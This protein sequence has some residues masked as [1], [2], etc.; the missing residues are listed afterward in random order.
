MALEP[1]HHAHLVNNKIFSETVVASSQ[2]D[3]GGSFISD[4]DKLL[5]VRRRAG[6]KKNL[7]IVVLVHGGPNVRGGYWAW[8]R[9]AQFLAPRGNVVLDPEFR[10]S[11]GFG[12][13]HFKAGL[14]AMGPGD[15]KRCCRRVI[16]YMAVPAASRHP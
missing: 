4:K 2:F 6:V 1:S 7:P 13:R 12:S 8:D 9:E 11:T 5:G 15:A 3:I 16:A 14:E 10:G